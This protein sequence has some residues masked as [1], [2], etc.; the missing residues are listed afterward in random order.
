MKKKLLNQLISYSY[1][2]NIIN[3][4]HVGLITRYLNRSD[5]LRYIKGL[6]TYE[7]KVCIFIDAPTN[8]TDINDELRNFF[9]D[10]K[11]VL[12]TDNSLMLGA[13]ILADDMLFELNLKNTLERIRLSI[14]ENYD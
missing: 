2:K 13:R 7:K 6:K 4:K 9:P 3:S 10:K 8:N 11:I 12:G 14:K 1:K 5:L